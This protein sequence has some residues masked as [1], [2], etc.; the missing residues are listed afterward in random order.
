L[1]AA[2]A[3][4]T[5]SEARADEAN[6][7]ADPSSRKTESAEAESVAHD[8]DHGPAWLPS[9]RHVRWGGFIQADWVAMNQSS[10]DEVD[11]QGQPIN[12]DRIVLR[13]ARMR[14][15]IDRGIVSGALEI[16]GNTVNGPQMRPI[17]AEVS[18]R[19]P[20]TGAGDPEARL[21]PDYDFLL[22]LGLMQTPF[23]Y[24]TQELDPA[25]P[26]LERSNV[27][28]AFFPGVYDLGARFRG[29]YKFLHYAVG[30]MNGDPIGEKAFP[31]RDPNKSKDLVF[32]VG[33]KTE[34]IRG[35]DVNA[36]FSGLTGSGFHEGTPTT[37]DQ[38]VWRDT[39]EDGIVDT[40]EIQVIAGSAAT[41]SQ[42]FKRFGIGAD[43][44]VGMRVPVLGKLQLRGEIMRGNNLDRG[45]FIADPV[46]VGRDLRELGW[47]VGVS[48]E[49]TRYGLVG[50][51]Y[52]H[53]DPDSDALEQQGVSFVPR[54][55]SVSTWAFL[56][57]VKL[58]SERGPYHAGRLLFEYDKNTNALGRGQ[59]GLPATLASDTAIL[60]AE[61]TF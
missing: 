23:G 49:V 13:R 34:I 16:D 32:R 58:P 6:T 46:S 54:D 53:Y 48:Q 3:V 57:G 31:G 47:Y 15:E 8:E 7:S 12:Q 10:Q 14:A 1:A 60:R 17:D 26:F 5:A 37:K 20:V 21:R 50:V 38:L 45:M 52:D 9:V 28:N 44:V 36:G 61:I 42:T 4:L 2:C 59:N 24:E 29:R 19:W 56:G 43:L 55:K 30:L 39:N 35:V 51:R 11:T 27:S 41:P 22:T 18:V 33:V 25:R 40:S